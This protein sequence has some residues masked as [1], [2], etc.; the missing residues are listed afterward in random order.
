MLTRSLCTLVCLGLLISAPAFSFDT[1]TEL[2]HSGG[3]SFV[4]CDAET[5]TGVC[6]G[7]A[8][9]VGA[10]VGAFTKFTVTFTEAGG[11]GNSCDIYSLDYVAAATNP[12]S[13]ASIGNRL[14]ATALSSSLLSYYFER[15]AYLVWAVCTAGT[16]S[17][18]VNIQGGS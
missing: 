1:A 15:K 17:F 18:S 7:A 9:D 3:S 6:E 10:I 13:L 16:G 12:G 11:T 14:T 8:G 4:L 2:V 5:V